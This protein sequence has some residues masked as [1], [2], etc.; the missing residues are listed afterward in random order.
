VY[1]VSI[2]KETYYVNIIIFIIDMNKKIH[3]LLL[4]VLFLFSKTDANALTYYISK[5]GADTNSG[6]QITSPLLTIQRGLNLAKPGDTIL[7]S[8]GVYNET[9]KTIVNGTAAS[10]ITIDGQNVA[11]VKGLTLKNSH[12]IIK[13]LTITGETN[14]YARLVFFDY[15]AHF[16]TITNCVI[17]A[18]KSL[19]L[20]GLE[21]R[22]PSATQLP[23][24]NGNVASDNLII[25]N[26]IKNVLGITFVSMCGDRN[27][28]AK[29]LIVDGGSAD[30]IRLFGRSNLI[31]GNICSNNVDVAGTGNHPD[32][33]QTFGNNGF[34]S[35]GHVIEKNFVHN[36]P[37]AQI[38]QMEANN[39]P[40]IGNWV[41]RNN[42]FSYIGLQ[43]SISVP[44]LKFYNNIFYKCNYISGGHALSI[45]PRTYTVG[46][47][48]Y[49][50]GTTYPN[51][52]VILNNIF[53]DCGNSR[54]TVGW[55]GFTD[56]NLTNL[57]ADYN[58]VGKANFAVVDQDPLKRSV[59][60]PTGWATWGKW[61]EP[62][63][64][65]GGDVNF[66]NLLESDF[67]LQSTS[68]LLNQAKSIF[69]FNDDFDGNPRPELGWDIGP[70]QK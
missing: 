12:H 6:V 3:I 63:G 60:S 59:G 23:Y 45:G 25:N 35:S 34:G 64:I 33:V 67:R 19:R 31:T 8:K 10:K 11:T 42:I 39:L 26:K 56:Q 68:K 51:G 28:L 5:N 7:L 9:A 14:Q 1:D 38:M 18:N 40:T 30:I 24:G 36:M 43:A 70:F 20:Y 16:N 61:W 53:L 69:G 50:A 17:D 66:V 58:Y 13:N 54:N 15:N 32:F 65:N 47:L 52:I 57:V 21:W 44:D 2:K 62:H 4:L 29:N 48:Y 49:P 27:I 22:P 37:A 41:F 46:T 55:Y